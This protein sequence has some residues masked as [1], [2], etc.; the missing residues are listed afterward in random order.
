MRSF[1][2]STTLWVV[3]MHSEVIIPVVWSDL[4]LL[5]P[6]TIEQ[7]KPSV[8][9]NLSAGVVDYDYHHCEVQSGVEFMAQYREDEILYHTLFS[10]PPTC[11]GTV[12]EIGGFTGKRYS[13]SWFFQYALGWRA[14]L[15]EALPSNF[16]QMVL[17]RPGAIH[18]SGAICFGASTRFQTGTNRATGGIAQDMSEFHIDRWTDAS[19]GVLEVACTILSDVFKN[20]GID[21]VDVFFLD[22]EGGELTVLKTFDWSVPIDMIVVEMDGSNPRKDESVRS[23][24]REHGYLTPFSLHDECIKK[25]PRCSVNELF[26]QEK[27]WKRNK[28]VDEIRL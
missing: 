19:T 15:V 6:K 3:V 25:Q 1:V 18:V 28:K 14:L 23:V 17:N 7:K 11:G 12:V 8:A 9:G 10:D 2:L 13:N 16:E 24:L 26:V 4:Q 20:N 5:D 21:H 22:V 27:V